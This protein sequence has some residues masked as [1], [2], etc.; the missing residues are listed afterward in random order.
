M[1]GT[2][3]AGGFSP[4]STARSLRS[5]TLGVLL[6][7][8]KRPGRGRRLCNGGVPPGVGSLP[9][10]CGARAAGRS[11]WLLW[12]VRVVREF[13]RGDVRK[14]SFE[15]AVPAERPP[16]DSTHATCCA[17]SRLRRARPGSKMS[18]RT[19]YAIL[20]SSIGWKPTCISKPRPTCSAPRRSA[21]PANCR[22]A[23]AT[24]RR[25]PRS[26]DSAMRSDGEGGL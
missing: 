14:A 12:S 17:P 24:K 10:F 6:F 16:T 7:V 1:R 13:V 25:G 8:L 21:P 4:L 22:G 20:Q 9:L 26:R 23:P 15:R 18:A 5:A 2:R 11:R 3:L 19:R